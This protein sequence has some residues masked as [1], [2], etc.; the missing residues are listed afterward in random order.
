MNNGRFGPYVKF[1]KAFVSLPKGTNP[2]DVDDFRSVSVDDS[3]ETLE[4]HV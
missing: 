4:T 1:G 3:S 2:M